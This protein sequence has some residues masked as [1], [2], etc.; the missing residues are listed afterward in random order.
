MI[1]DQKKVII[2]TVSKKLSACLQ[3]APAPECTIKMKESIEKTY[4][5]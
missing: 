5:S 2:N 1:G 4:T 3:K